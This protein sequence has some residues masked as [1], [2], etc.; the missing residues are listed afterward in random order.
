M[1][2]HKRL[3]QMPGM[4]RGAGGEAHCEVSAA[5]V[6][7]TTIG[8]TAYAYRS[9][10]SVSGELPDGLYELL[11]AGQKTMLRNFSGRWSRF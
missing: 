10:S 5:E 2:S 7:N 4:L 3:V 1:P 11:W 6:T 9:V 8:Q